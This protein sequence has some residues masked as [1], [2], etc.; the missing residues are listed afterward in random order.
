MKTLLL[1]LFA[2]LT[3]N[4]NAQ[5]ISGKITD[6]K[7]EAQFG[8]TVALLRSADSALVKAAVTDNDGVF[9]FEQP[10]AGKYIVKAFFIGFETYWYPS[11]DYNGTAVKLTDASLLSS[12]KTLK[13]VS[14][15]GVKPMIELKADKT[16]FNVENSINSTGSTAFELLQKSPGVVVDQNDNVILKGK[17]GVMIQIDGKNTQLSG[18]DLADL[19]KSMQSSDVSSIELISNPSS[20][21]D[22]EGTAGIINI[23]LKKNKDFGTNGSLTAG[24]AVG[25]FSKYNTGITLNNRS[26]GV[27]VFMNYS[28][29]WGNRR[30]YIDLIREQN[31]VKYDQKS[32][33]IRNGLNHNYK[34]GADF[35]LNK[36]SSIGVMVNGNYGDINNNT[37]S[38]AEIRNLPSN[39]LNSFLD[40]SSENTAVNNNVNVNT[41]YHYTDTAGHEFSIDLDYG[42]YNSDRTSFQPN[43]YTYFDGNAPQLH[44]YRTITPTDINIYSFKSDYST[45]FLKGTLGFGIKSAYVETDNTFNFYNIT[46]NTDVLDTARSNKFVYTESVSAAYINYSHT[47]KKFELQVGV[48]SEY[49]MSEGDLTSSVVTSD[50]NVKRDYLDVFPSAG[51]TYQMNKK[52]NFGLV[53]SSRIDRPNYQDLNPFE[54]KLDELSYR[55]GNPFLDP[56]YTY[57]VEVSHSYNYAINTTFGYSRTND[58]SAQVTDTIEGNKSF[59]SPRNLASEDVF[60]LDINVSTQIKKWWGLYTNITASNLSYNADFGGGRTLDASVYTLNIYAQNTFRL[61]AGFNFELSGWFS[62]PSIWGGTFKTKT[63]GSLDAGLQKK[64]LSDRLTLKLSVTDIFVTAPW[65]STSAFEVIKIEANGGWE[66]RQFRANLTWRFGSKTVK[67]VKARSTGNETETKRV[68]GGE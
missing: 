53:F 45:P 50:E 39:E 4:A 51:V 6:E 43:Q 52:N 15:S 17:S 48:R 59:L 42:L 28:N 21:Y 9:S 20:K 67:A 25:I 26:N 1:I 7:K 33:S 57:K 37:R 47:I 64:F 35:T 32:A 38:R 36:K 62:T 11:F 16:V 27:N 41:N 5:T 18:T 68:G 3:L 12:N 65:R 55:K 10:A 24:Y 54:W 46:D 29:N 23:K 66:T 8:V 34:A 44:L 14:I 40:A 58:Y 31:D 63:G 30:N 49:T 60:S 13:E 56:Q 22:A 2:A 61:P 19:L